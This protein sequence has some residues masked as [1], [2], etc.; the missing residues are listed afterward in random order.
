MTLRVVF[1]SLLFFF[2]FFFFLLWFFY[3]SLCCF[4]NPLTVFFPVL[5]PFVV[6]WKKLSIRLINKQINKYASKKRKVF[7]FFC[8]LLSQSLSSSSLSSLSQYYHHE[9]ELSWLLFFNLPSII[10]NH[11][12][13]Y[14]HAFGK[15]LSLKLNF[16]LSY[17]YMQ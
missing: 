10:K 5:F 6:T 4:L 7:V 12:S 3:F 14:F 1:L 16:I 11:Q 9:L 2:Y 17:L 8:F 13:Y 15:V